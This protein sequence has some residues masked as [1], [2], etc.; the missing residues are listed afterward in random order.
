M[1]E[2]PIP[3]PRL[4][5]PPGLS[6]G[7]ERLLANEAWRT[8]CGERRVAIGRASRSVG[9]AGSRLA[10]FSVSMANAP[11][12]EVSP[13]NR[14]GLLASAV[15]ATSANRSGPVK[16]QRFRAATPSC[17]AKRGDTSFFH[18]LKQSMVNPKLLKRWRAKRCFRPR[19]WSAEPATA[20]AWEFG[21]QCLNCKA[22]PFRQ[23]W[24]SLRR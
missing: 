3:D 12:C 10:S 24:R 5:R 15:P 2:R 13:A 7:I 8:T 23:G 1:A 18:P 9:K 14:G 4:L 11:S 16:G 21:A 19:A 6:S 22:Y 20:G 17:A